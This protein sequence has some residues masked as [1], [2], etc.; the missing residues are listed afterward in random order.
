MDDSLV[1]SCA[2]AGKSDDERLC[3]ADVDATACSGGL[4]MIIT[5]P[6]LE[7]LS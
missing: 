2:L 6:L 3:D 1:E 7:L 5:P 4:E